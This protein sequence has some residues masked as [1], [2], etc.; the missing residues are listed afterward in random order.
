[1]PVRLTANGL[2]VALEFDGPVGSD[3]SLLGI[4]LAVEHL[5]GKEPPPH[6]F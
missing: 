5:L 1:M 4:G 6:G 3:R 2:P